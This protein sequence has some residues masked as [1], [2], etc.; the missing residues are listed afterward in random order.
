MALKAKITAEE[1]KAMPAGLQAAYIADGAEFKL[2]VVGF[3]LED[4]PAALLQARTHERDRANALKAELDKIKQETQ[5]NIW[6]NELHSQRLTAE[7]GLMRQELEKLNAQIKGKG[8]PAANTENKQVFN[9]ERRG[10]RSH[11]L[12]SPVMARPILPSSARRAAS[13]L[14]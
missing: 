14:L 13:G 10:T 11:P 3:I 4:D 6:K 9:L 2:D 7:L 8:K 12:I 1:Y 5:E